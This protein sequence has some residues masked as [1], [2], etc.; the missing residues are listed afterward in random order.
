MLLFYLNLSYHSLS[1]YNLLLCAQ[2][3]GDTC[4]RD[5]VR[6]DDF[7]LGDMRLPVTRLARDYA[8]LYWQECAFYHAFYH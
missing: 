6:F 7:D 4:T 3:I 5:S 2:E 1:Y 8:I